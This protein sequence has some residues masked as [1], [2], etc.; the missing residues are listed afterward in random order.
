MNHLV[1]YAHPNPK[2]FNHAILETYIQELRKNHH[3]VRIRD[4]YSFLFD[5]V[6]QGAELAS[7]G[8][9]LSVDIIEEQKHVVWAHTLT[10][11]FPLWWGGMPAL[12]KGYLDRVFTEG[13]AYSFNEKGLNRLLKEKKV[14]TITTLGDQKKIYEDKGFIQAMNLLWNGIAFDFS[15]LEVIGNIYFGSVPWVSEEDRKK[16][17]EEVKQIAQQGSERKIR[18]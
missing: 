13:F 7:G 9:R 16:M 8:K 6:L 10:F 5:P 2:S 17:L 11:I 3:E 15:G 12:A 14:L 4:L 1:I 18:D